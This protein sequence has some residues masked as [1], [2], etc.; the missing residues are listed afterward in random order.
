MTDWYLSYVVEKIVGHEFNKK[1][2]PALQPTEGTN[3]Q[4]AD[5]NLRAIYF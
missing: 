4:P 1:V 3:G 5:S 2:L